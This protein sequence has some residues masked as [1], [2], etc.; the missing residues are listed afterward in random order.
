VRDVLYLERIEQAEALLKPARVEVLRALAEPS[1]CTKVARLL[2][3][4]PQRVNYHVKVL[5]GQGLVEQ[6]AE[7]QVRNLREGTFQAAARTYWLSPALVGPVGDRRASDDRSL[8]H[9]LELAEQIQHDVAG[10]DPARTDRPSIGLS[11]QIHIR[12]E[13]RH[14]FLAEVQTA[15]QDLFTKYGGRDGEAFNLALACYPIEPQPSA[16]PST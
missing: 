13:Q 10:I 4:T 9:L 6:V 2:G 14:R 11:G 15:L 8:G 5:V 12:P 16:T 3:Q 1:T 7:R